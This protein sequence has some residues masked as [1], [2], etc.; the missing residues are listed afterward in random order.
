MRGEAGRWGSEAVGGVAGGSGGVVLGGRVVVGARVSGR[1]ERSGRRLG[2][3][4][5]WGGAWGYIW[6]SPQIT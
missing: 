6:L 5:H 4:R 2:F 3:G 1:L